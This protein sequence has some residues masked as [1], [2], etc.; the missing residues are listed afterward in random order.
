[1][2]SIIPFQGFLAVLERSFCLPH[3]LQKAASVVQ[4]IRISGIETERLVIAA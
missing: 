3:R 1:M 2:S 4:D